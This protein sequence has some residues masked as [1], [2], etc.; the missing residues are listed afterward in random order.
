MARAI[1]IVFFV[2]GPRVI[3]P[4]LVRVA[5]YSILNR[6]RNGSNPKP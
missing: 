3:E 4:V 1:V 5:M 2:I 6:D